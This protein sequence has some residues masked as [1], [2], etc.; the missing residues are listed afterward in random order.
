MSHEVEINADGTAA[1]AYAASGGLPRHGLGTALPDDANTATVMAA[2]GLAGWDVKKVR[3]ATVLPDGT[4]LEAPVVTDDYGEEKKDAGGN[5]VYE[6][7]NIVRTGRLPD[8]VSGRVLGYGVTR[9]YEPV[10]NE[11]AFGVFEPAFDK[12]LLQYETAISLQ[13]GRRVVILAKVK[14]ATQDIAQADPVDPYILLV[15]GNDGRKGIA[16]RPTAVRVVCANTLRVAMSVKDE[17]EI[18]VPHTRNVRDHLGFMATAIENT[19]SNF[20]NAAE[21][22]R[23]MAAKKL[24]EEEMEALLEALIPNPE[25]NASHAEKLRTA[26]MGH[27]AESPGCSGESAWDLFNGVTWHVTHEHGQNAET[28]F[29][30]DQWGV[31][32]NLRDNAFHLLQ[33]A[34]ELNDVGEAISMFEANQ[35]LGNRRNLEQVEQQIYATG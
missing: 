15:K 1:M 5:P 3:A 32:R 13:E 21:A 4:V 6:S 23:R 9:R 22:Y 20:T 7:Y 12:G 27:A 30:A 16:M 11:E 24:R 10:Q 26:I 19:R 25:K 35:I 34:T 2:G 14:D 17:A 28:R 29:M 18:N 33:A 8:G 31:G